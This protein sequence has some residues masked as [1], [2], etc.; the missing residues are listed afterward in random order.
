LAYFDGPTKLY[1]TEPYLYIYTA[2]LRVFDVSAPSLPK[3]LGRLEMD[4]GRASSLHRASAVVVSGHY[5]YVASPGICAVDISNPRQPSSDSCTALPDDA[6]DLAVMGGYAYVAAG[7]AGLR[8]VD[9]ATTKGVRLVEPGVPED[10]GDV[11]LD[12]VVQSGNAFL[13][14]YR[15]L[16]IVDVSVTAKLRRVGGFLYSDPYTTP[17]GTYP[18][19]AV[20]GRYAYLP[21]YQTV[22]VLDVSDP[23]TVQEVGNYYS[24]GSAYGRSDFVLSVQVSGSSL[25]V[26]DYGIGLQVLDISKPE[27]PR[28]STGYSCQ[29][30][31]ALEVDTSRHFAFVGSDQ[32]LIVVNLDSPSEK[33]ILPLDGF[34][35]QQ[36]ILSNQRLYI[37]AEEAGLMI[38]DVSNPMR[39]RQLG[40]LDMP[41]SAQDVFLA[42]SVAFI[43]DGEAGL[44]VA[45]VKDPS[46]PFELASWETPDAAMGVFVVG[47]RAYLAAAD[48]GLVV[49]QFSLPGSD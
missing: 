11:A 45:N 41:G 9:V 6:Y 15:G 17:Y 5:A 8:T 20:S 23:G 48:A 38:I 42:G 21:D 7:S 39:P 47:N 46:H 34:R 43:A 19:L 22:S 37:A 35:P 36:I 29:H 25:Y 31:S 13:I 4:M 2:F 10:Q 16:S 32:G 49:I 44:R 24:G 26:T 18:H 27:N 1:V 30:C 28:Y 3:E 14:N 33:A 40:Q 12:V